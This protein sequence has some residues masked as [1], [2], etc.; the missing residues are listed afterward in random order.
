MT[1]LLSIFFNYL[2]NPQE[3]SD[4]RV[5]TLNISTFLETLALTAI[6]SFS[7]TVYSGSMEDIGQYISADAVI[8]E[9]MQRVMVMY[10]RVISF[11]E[12]RNDKDTSR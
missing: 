4:R 11:Q 8:N 10:N 2:I 5:N 6:I 12:Y 7:F 1:K 9:N 3:I